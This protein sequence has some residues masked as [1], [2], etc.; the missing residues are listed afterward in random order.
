MRSADVGRLEHVGTHELRSRFPTDFMDTV[1]W[2]SS[3]ACGCAMPMRRRKSA[4][5]L[6]KLSCTAAPFAQTP[7]QPGRSSPTSAKSVGDR[8]RSVGDRVQPRGVTAAVA[9]PEDLRQRTRSAAGPRCRNG[10]AARCNCRCRAAP[11]AWP[12]R[13]VR[14]ARLVVAEHVG[15]QACAPV[16]GPGGLVVR[17]LVRGH[18]QRCDGV[19]QRGLAR[20]DV[21]CQQPVA[22][23]ESPASTPARRRCPSCRSQ[24]AASG[25]RSS[26]A[27]YRSSSIMS[28][29]PALPAAEYSASRIEVAPATGRRRTP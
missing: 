25:T 15:P 12:C 20:S 6:L 24:G 11:R 21:A 19:D 27:S 10:R 5:Y 16:F 18:Q 28:V 7:A 2:N 3:S 1:W 14:R 29:M 8:Q 23:V 26:A 17:D 9:E 22:T 13:S 4:A